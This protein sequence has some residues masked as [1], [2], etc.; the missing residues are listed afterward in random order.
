MKLLRRDDPAAAIA[1]AQ[2]AIAAAEAKI[3]ELVLRRADVLLSDNL[4]DVRAVDRALDEQRQTININRERIAVLE[5]AQRQQTA[6]R[7]EQERLSGI[8]NVR[9]RT[10][11]RHEAARKLDAAIGEV[12]GA[13]AELLSAD[14]DL[15][16][17]W[18]ATVSDLG[19]LHH[20]RVEGLEPLSAR[21]LRRPPSAGLVR[22]IAEHT[23]FNF[24]DAIEARN[25]ELVEMIEVVPASGVAA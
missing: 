13:F 11:S 9:K 21:R 12:R 14:N 8:A 7:A 19:R 24:A 16:G 18:P 1:K 2:E 17:N 15:F 25:R 20:F 5:A 22:C 10:A 6:A 4:E 3:S 23:A